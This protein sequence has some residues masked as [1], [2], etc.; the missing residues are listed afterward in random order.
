MGG[1]AVDEGDLRRWPG[2]AVGLA[3]N[4][5]EVGEFEGSICSGSAAK[6]CG[7]F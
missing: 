7:E 6:V 4:G 2:A 1:K 5:T 3:D